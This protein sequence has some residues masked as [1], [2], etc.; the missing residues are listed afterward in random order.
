LKEPVQQTAFSVPQVLPG[1]GGTAN[2]P[3]VD[4]I[5]GNKKRAEAKNNFFIALSLSQS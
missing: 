5:N 1:G 4:I 3:L 2:A